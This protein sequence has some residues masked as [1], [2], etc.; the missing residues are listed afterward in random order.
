MVCALLLFFAPFVLAAFY[1]LFQRKLLISAPAVADVA[2]LVRR[3]NQ[4]EVVELFSAAR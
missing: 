4:R 3:V 1:F 2:A